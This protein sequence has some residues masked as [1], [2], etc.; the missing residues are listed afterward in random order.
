MVA[1]LQSL[2]SK[3]LPAFRAI[4]ST[5]GLKGNV[6]VAT[7]DGQI[8]ASILVLDEMKCNL[9]VWCVNM[10]PRRIRILY[11]SGKPFCCKYAIILCPNKLDVRII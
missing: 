1:L 6:E 5:C 4:D 3:T 2:L 9:V 11:T 8:E 10:L 7:F